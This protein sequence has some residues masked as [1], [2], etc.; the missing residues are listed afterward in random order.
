MACGKFAGFSDGCNRHKQKHQRTKGLQ[1]K[2]QF[3]N[4]FSTFH[5]LV[6]KFDN[7]VGFTLVFHSTIF[8]CTDIQL[9]NLNSEKGI[10]SQDLNIGLLLILALTKPSI[11]TLKVQHPTN[12]KSSHMNPL[13]PKLKDLAKK[14]QV[15]TRDPGECCFF[16]CQIQMWHRELELLI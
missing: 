16:Q 15:P 5:S 3:P 14:K 13:N 1:K 11:L 6:C 10:S 8:R 7:D 4:D 9:D 2:I 12:L